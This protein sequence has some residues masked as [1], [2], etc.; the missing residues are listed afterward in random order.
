MSHG[1]DKKGSITSCPL[2]ATKANNV[3]AHDRFPSDPDIQEHNLP[4]YEDL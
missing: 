3:G 1:I 2:E 4:I